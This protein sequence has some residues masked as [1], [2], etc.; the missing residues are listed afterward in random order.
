VR[1]PLALALPLATL[2][3]LRPLFGNSST[4]RSMQNLLN[5]LRFAVRSLRKQPAFTATA[6]AT[7]ALAIGASTAIFSVVESAL[8]RPLPFQTPERLGFLQA[9]AGPE[10]SSRGVS[11][12]EAQDWA[13]LN[14]VF[15]SVSIY[16]ETSLNLRTADGAERVEA[17]MVS[18]AYFTM[19]GQQ[20]A[21]GRVFTA[22]EDRVSAAAP[23]V[24]ISDAMWNARFGGDSSIIGRSLVFNDV[25]FTVVGVMPPGFKGISFDTEVW[26]P[27]A[28]VR[29]NG[30]PADLTDRGARLY[31][32][33][34]RLRAGAT[35]DQGQADLGRV[36]AELARDFPETNRDREIRFVALRDS[37]L[38]STRTVML[39]VFVAVVLLLLIACANVI[40]LQLVRASVRRREIA[41]RMAIG[42]GRARLVQQLVVEGLVLALASAGGGI[43]VSYWV[44]EGLTALAPAGVLPLFATPTINVAAFLFAIG[45]AVGCGFLFGLIP[46]LRGSRIDLVDS[47]KEGS[48]GSAERLGGARLGPQQL[49]LVGET[50]VAIVLLVGAGLFVR[51]LQRQLAVVTGF[52]A[53][54]VL[55]ARI[56]APT[57]YTAEMR[58]QLVEQLQQRFGNIPSVQAV[59]IGSDLPLGGPTNAAYLYVP[60]V[61]S[62]VRYYRHVVAPDF[63]RAL[64]VRVNSGRVFTSEDRERTPAV[65]M[66]NESMARRF[67]P[68]NTPI[69]KRVRFGGASGPEA[70]IV[71]VVADVRYRDLTT[72]IA[73]TEPDVYLPFAQRPAAGLVIGIRS[74]AALETLVSA[75]RSEL[76]AVDRTI[77]LFCIRPLESLVA[78]QSSISRFASSLL[79][80]FGVAALVLTAVGLYGVLAFLVSVRRREIGIRL[81]LGATSG[82]VLGSVLIH[83]LRLVGLG[84][85][86]GVIGAAVGTRWIATQLYGV[87]AH[88]PVVFVVVPVVLVI[89]ASIASWVPARRAAGLDPQIALRSE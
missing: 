2:I 11:F 65:V 7:L 72:P 32:A 66:I 3:R 5:D 43:V 20:A 34:G 6:I 82:R 8:L 85:L 4:P 86:L 36:A 68:M 38:G 17:E 13:R 60:E 63:F 29:A 58:V 83:G 73:T 75:L 69:G 77:P 56:V 30:G 35:I 50:A 49:L 76:S 24:T 87:G 71:G 81:A 53:R 57:R 41:L 1:T 15:E 79:I 61:N 33:L 9:V 47:L 52:E 12:V 39:A 46:A 28:M 51:S 22:E 44:L 25:S 55:R 10:R 19:V 78:Q 89:V 54:G 16:D 62:V 45:V 18:A 64:G 26:F 37:Y 40:G 27:S 59:A 88:D 14:R 80:V 23:V 31:S 74:D 84:L 67:W 42:A 48:R 21:R 70:T